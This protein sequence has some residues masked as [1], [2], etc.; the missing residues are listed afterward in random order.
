M[1]PARPGLSGKGRAKKAQGKGKNRGS[2]HCSHSRGQPDAS[3]GKRVRARRRQPASSSPHALPDVLPNV[4]QDM[5]PCRQ[6][7]ASRCGNNCSTLRK[8]CRQ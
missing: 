6:T 3:Q 5:L 2:S 7:A 8:W 1:H 4:R